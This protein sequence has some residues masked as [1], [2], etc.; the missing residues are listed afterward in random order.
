MNWQE[1][2]SDPK[3]QD[4]PF[5]IELN[6]WGQVVMSPVKVIHSI[7]QWEIQRKIFELLNKGRVVPECAIH[8]SKGTKAADVAW[9]SEERLKIVKNQVECSIAP[10]ICVEVLSE[11]N[12][13]QEMIEKKEL[14]FE[15]GAKEV[16]ICDEQGNIRFYLPQGKSASSHLVQDFP[17]KISV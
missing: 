9:I 5:K 7:L 14:Y 13:E 16:W 4:L 2:C 11:S 1:V 8:T 10:E 17:D 3:L 12:S 15:A 6:Q